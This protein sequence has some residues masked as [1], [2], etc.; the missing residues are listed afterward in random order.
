MQ[1][2]SNL[3]VMEPWTAGCQIVALNYQTDDRQNLL[4][5]AMFAG[6]GGCGYILKPRFLRE[7]KMH[8]SPC[9]PAWQGIDKPEFP[10]LELTVEVILRGH[11]EDFKGDPKPATK[12]VKDNGFNPCWN[13]KFTFNIKVPDVAILELKVKD[14][15]KTGKDEHLGSFAARINDMQ[16]GYR[17]A[18]LSDY[19][20]KELRPASLFLKVSKK[21]D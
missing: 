15:S 11:N 12:P 7:P 3:K 13:T 5:R 17:Q 6:N 19:S 20:G 4:N 8:Y 10:G 9:K 16:E 2:S 18:F 21:W 1:D 14:H